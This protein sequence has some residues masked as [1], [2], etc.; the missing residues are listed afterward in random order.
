VPA[1]KKEDP[2][3]GIEGKATAPA[4]VQD[5]YIDPQ[6]KKV[7]MFVWA[8]SGPGVS[9][10]LGGP[11]QRAWATAEEKRCSGKKMRKPGATGTGRK[12][13]VPGKVAVNGEPGID[14]RAEKGICKLAAQKEILRGG[15]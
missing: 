8:L 5:Q 12:K 7:K 10:A 3:K 11:E 15:K 6:R 13:E 14:G 9:K 2:I 4:F 1:T